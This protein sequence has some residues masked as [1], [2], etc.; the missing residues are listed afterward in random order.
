[1]EAWADLGGKD[2]GK[3]HEAIWSLISVPQQSVPFLDERLRPVAF[4]A[5]QLAQWLADLEDIELGLTVLRS[6][7]RDVV[8]LRAGAAQA[9]LFN[10]DVAPRLLTRPSKSLEPH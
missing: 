2:G 1:M 9:A 4:D 5:G 8:A 6:L 10:A 3:A 7:L